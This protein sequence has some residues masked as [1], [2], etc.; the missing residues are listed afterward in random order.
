MI[1]LRLA[2]LALPAAL[3]AAACD[4]PSAPVGAAPDAAPSAAA[5]PDPPPPAAAPPASAPAAPADAPAAAADAAAP[6]DAGAPAEDAGRKP[7]VD[8][9]DAGGAAAAR[10]AGGGAAGGGAAGGGA[11][12]DAGGGRA[13]APAA[14]GGSPPVA[15]APPLAPPEAG[16]ADAVAAEVDAIF[17]GKKTYVARFKQEHTQKIS[18]AVKK[19]SG[20]LSVQKPD[21]ISFRYDPP[22]RNRIVSDGVS[23]KVYVAEDRQMFVTP[24]KNSEYPGALSFLMG[25]GLRPSFTFTFNEK[26][27]FQGG[28]VLVGKPRAPTPHYEL[29]MFYI[30]SALLAKKDPGVV[31][32][33]LIVDAQGNRNRFD[34]ESALQPASIDPAEFQF[35]PPPGTD[36]KQN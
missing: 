28:P 13:E 8:A 21:R 27:S 29:V 31:R 32:R 15:E 2:A 4:A 34:F 36:V 11:A 12:R 16:S 6:A 7:S 25:H 17:V 3:A 26:A 19:Q 24:V 1:R 10:D 5:P 14:T 18:G 20:A 22:S 35:T 33:V 23:L 9:G 30:D